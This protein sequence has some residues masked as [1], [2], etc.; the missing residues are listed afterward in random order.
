MIFFIALTPTDV[1]KFFLILV[2]RRDFPSAGNPEY[3]R[4]TLE[5]PH[6]ADVC[7]S[8]T[9]SGS[10]EASNAE[11]RAVTGGDSKQNHQTGTLYL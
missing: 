3:Q 8:A 10:G 2:Q 1:K 7:Q 9:K 4:E 11:A 6:T 5:P